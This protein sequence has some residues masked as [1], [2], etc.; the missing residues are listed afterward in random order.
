[1]ST[2]REGVLMSAN[3]APVPQWRWA[4][5][6]GRAIGL[7]VVAVAALKAS[8]E[9]HRVAIGAALAV[10]VAGAA[11]GLL[12][13]R[14]LWGQRLIGL[15]GLAGGGVALAVIDPHGPGWLAG[16]IAIAAGLVRLPT[17]PGLIFMAATGV[18]LTVAPLVRGETGQVAVNASICGGCAVL[19]MILE[20]SRSRAVTAER[21]LASEQAARESAA[22]AERY[23]ERQRLAR[24]IHDILAHTLSAQTVQLEGAR[25]LLEH[26]QPVGEVRQRIES[27][28]RLARDGLEETRR[29]VH[30]LRGQTRPLPETLQELATTAGATYRQQG[31]PR[32]VPAQ[33][34]LA[35]ERT[36]QEALTNARK[37]APGAAVTVTMS[38]GDDHDEVEVCDDGATGAHAPLSNTGSGYGLA[39]MRERAELIGA[40]LATG[41]HAVGSGGKGYRVWL[42]VPRNAP[43]AS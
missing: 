27:A 7:V 21:L 6:V 1:M 15:V 28:Q 40:K 8:P 20:N 2:H 26:G 13:A 37:H 5:P 30:S 14:P 36:V 9:G 24:E 19:G 25:L 11:Y 3:D 29:A 35:I 18:A 39:G 22:E 41:P 23:A 38:F 34:A 33:A 10:C 31:E 42:T 17:R 43:S 32:P 4:L 12:F 16:A